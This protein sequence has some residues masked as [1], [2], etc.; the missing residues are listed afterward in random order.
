M[1]ISM[2]TGLGLWLGLGLGRVPERAE[3]SNKI[4]KLKCAFCFGKVSHL[5]TRKYKA[6]KT[7]MKSK[8]WNQEERQAQNETKREGHWNE[9]VLVRNYNELYFRILFLPSAL[10]SLHYFWKYIRAIHFLCSQH[11]WIF[12]LTNSESFA[13]FLR[14]NSIVQKMLKFFLI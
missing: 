3:L 4:M 11:K 13:I 14:E 1:R 5:D 9:S 10:L 7:I 2:E 6:I 12:K 8:E